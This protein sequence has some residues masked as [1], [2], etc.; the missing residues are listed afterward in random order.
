[1][2]E[3]L[4]QDGYPVLDNGQYSPHMLADALDEAM[5][6]KKVMTPQGHEYQA[7]LDDWHQS[8]DP[9]FG[10]TYGRLML[11]ICVWATTR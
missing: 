7:A 1:M 4:A 8:R 9:V 2:A 6:G 11:A 5:R 3:A 10:K